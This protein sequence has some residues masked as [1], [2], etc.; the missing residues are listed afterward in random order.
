MTAASTSAVIAGGGIG[1]LA[2]ALALAQHGIE[3]HVFERRPEFPEEGAGIQ[4]GPNGARILS[5]LGIAEL[6]QN[7]VAVPGALSVRDGATA[8]ELTRLPLGAWIEKRH[9][10]PYWTATRSDLHAALRARAE[11][12]PLVT[13]TRGTEISSFEE[14]ADAVRL[15][16]AQGNIQRASVLIAADGLWSGLRKEITAAAGALQ[17]HPKPVGKSAFRTVVPVE[18]L[19]STLE[20]N[21]VHIW[22]APRAHAVHYPVSAGREIALV[23]IGND[24]FKGVEW[25]APASAEAVNEKTAGFAA[26]LR[27]LVAA[28]HG[29]R[30]WSLH[31]MEPLQSW[32]AGRAALL[33]DA[34]HPF[35]PF[36]A[37]GAAMA[38]EDAV[39]LAAHLADARDG[40]AAV[41][42]AYALERRPRVMKVAAASRRNGR[43]YHMLGATAHARNTVMKVAPAA[44]LMACFDWLY[45]WRLPQ[46]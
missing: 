35:L 46:C 18:S 11:D 38:L 45:G 19:H 39:A 26:P 31:D 5:D 1:G 12:A 2:A 33:G 30:R 23:V 43:V 3:A 8:R 6:L 21:V 15:S 41:L 24:G 29:W 28:A 4:I 25:S 10:A 7:K 37:Q 17:R 9:G 14:C 40:V 44:R 13:L 36:L 22:L 32:T 20:A 16:S 42:R 34:A 27:S